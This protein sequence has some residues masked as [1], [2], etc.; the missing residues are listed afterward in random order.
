MPGDVKMATKEDFLA[1]GRAPALPWGK[2]AAWREAN[3]TLGF[4]IRRHRR[5]LA[6]A[7]TIA[8]RVQVHLA[9][10]FALMDDLCTATCRFCPDPCCLTA[11]VWIDFRDLLF[12]HLAGQP[13]PMAQLRHDLN[14]ACRCLGPKGCT[15]PRI[16]RPWVCA[17]YLCPPQAARLKKKAPPVQEN[18]RRAVQA[19][20]TGRKEMEAEF[21]RRVT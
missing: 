14:G 8:R 12:L 3:R 18:F 20:K 21:V 19:V 13:V 10:L 17:W 9:S 2:S 4:L 6:Q 1:G 11:K 15:L 7:V 16:S 5:E